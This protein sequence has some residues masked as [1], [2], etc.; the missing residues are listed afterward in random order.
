MG[1][2]Q[3]KLV[4]AQAQCRLFSIRAKEALSAYKMAFSHLKQEQV[5]TL[6]LPIWRLWAQ[7]GNG[8]LLSASELSGNSTPAILEH[9]PLF[10]AILMGLSL[11]LAWSVLWSLTKNKGLQRYLRFPTFKLRHLLLLS[12]FLAACFSLVAQRLIPVASDFSDFWLRAFCHLCSYLGLLMGV[13]LLFKI[14]QIQIW[15]SWN[16]LDEGFFRGLFIFLLTFYALHNMAML[17]EETFVVK[18]MALQLWKSSFL[19][20]QLLAGIYFIYY[21][22][23]CHKTLSFIKP[24]V[25]LIQ[26]T[27]ILVLMIMVLLDCIGYQILAQKLTVSVFYTLCILFL[28][29][30][31]FHGLNTLYDRADRHQATRNKLKKYFGYKPTQAITELLIFKINLAVFITGRRVV[32]YFTKLGIRR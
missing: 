26:V 7:I 23:H 22:C 6:G 4:D 18:E 3:K 25:T 29:A 11:G 19:L 31:S 5:L 9:T 32:F 12:L 1:K 24:H 28:I 30:L 27:F 8:P 2:E 10:L 16:K 20:S 14:K 21:F 17:L 15:L 13:I